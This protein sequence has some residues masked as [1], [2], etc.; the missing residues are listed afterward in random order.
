MA[1]LYLL[2]AEALNEWLETP[3]EEVYEYVNLVRQRAGLENVQDAWTKY[4]KN[5]D[6]YK[7][8]AG[9]QDI[10]HRERSIELAFEGQRFWDI[11]R[12][13][14]ATTELTGPVKGWNYMGNNADDFY[15]IITVDNVVFTDRDVLWPIRTA[16]LVININMVQS[17]GW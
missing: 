14:K 13:N 16:E 3:N 5:P 10:I 9:M 2:Y 12:W 8:K 1:D 4:A 11:R 17:P 7:S 6:K 15:Q